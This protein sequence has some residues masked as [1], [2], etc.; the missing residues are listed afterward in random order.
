VSG[1]RLDELSNLLGI[2]IGIEKKHIPETSPRPAGH[3]FEAEG[4]SMD[5]DLSGTHLTDELF[6]GYHMNTLAP[7]ELRAVERHLSDCIVC[8]EEIERIAE[9]SVIWNDEQE[10][11]RLQNR[12]AGV[13]SDSHTIPAWPPVRPQESWLAAF[14]KP[15]VVSLRPLIRPQGAYGETKEDETTTLEFSITQDGKIVDGLRGMLKRVNREY[16]VRIFAVDSGARTEFGDR[17]AVISI[18]DAY[19][20]RPILHRRIDIGVTVLLGTDFPLTDNSS[21]AVEMLPPFH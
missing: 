16:Y 11:A 21:L 12:V 20:E 3:G 17:K 8:S 7:A 15:F 1:V 6:V 2:G 13:L 10:I 5:E 18:S 14:V 9:L 4:F 19:Q